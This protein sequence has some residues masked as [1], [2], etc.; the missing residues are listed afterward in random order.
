MEYKVMKSKGAKEQTT[1]N[2]NDLKL[3]CVH[4]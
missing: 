2:N 4:S 1:F 3:N